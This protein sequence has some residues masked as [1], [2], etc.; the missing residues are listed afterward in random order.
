M[1]IKHC[2]RRGRC[3]ELDQLTVDDLVN[4]PLYRLVAEA[5]LIQPKQSGRYIGSCGLFV[6]DAEA[7]VAVRDLGGPSRPAGQQKRRDLPELQVEDRARHNLTRSGG[8]AASA[9]RGGWP[10]LTSSISAMRTTLL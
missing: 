2:A 9:R 7:E 10:E 6:V 1:I 8:P 3:S 4:N 5:L